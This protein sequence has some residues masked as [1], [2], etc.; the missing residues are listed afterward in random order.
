MKQRAQ[1]T[2]EFA[3]AL[4]VFLMLVFMVIELGRVFYAWAT[5]ENNARAAARYLSTGQYDPSYCSAGCATD[6][7]RA[8]AR[9]QSGIAR[10][11]EILFGLL[12]TSFGNQAGGS[13]DNVP[14]FYGVTICSS[15]QGFEFDP[16]TLECRP[17]ND[18]GG[19]GDR[20]IVVI[21]HNHMVITPIL[22]QITPFIPLI[23]R[24]DIINEE[25]RTVRLLGMPPTVVGGELPTATPTPLP[26]PTFTPT[27]SPTPSPTATP[28]PTPTFTPTPT[29]T[30]T[31]TRTPTRTPTVTLT[32]TPTPTRTPTPTL[33]PPSICTPTPTPTATPT[34]TPTRTPT[35]T[36][37]PTLT[38]TRTPT[39]TLC[40]PS[41]CTPTP[42][43]TATPTRTPTRT[44]TVTLTPTLTPT[45]TITP[46]WT[47]T[48]TP[49]HTPTRTP[50]S[51]PPTPTRTATPTPGGYDG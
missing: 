27:P 25:F 3:I 4:P 33:C 5:I 47:P 18:A 24:R 38:P 49:T 12:I 37:T 11:R 42:T 44:P 35:V 32:P 23:A 1:G 19:P 29:P 41:V 28:T 40:P 43:P 16:V 34:R 15:R 13:G 9:L 6:G 45:P 20:V 7:D 2:L 17:T 26:T 50:T 10:A 36:L 48:R 46:T 51:N 14:G 30:A 31:P 21:R 22:R 39:P 8:Q